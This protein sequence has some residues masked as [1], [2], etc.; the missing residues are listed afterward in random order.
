V[1]VRP[2][3]TLAGIAARYGTSVA[4]LVELNQIRN[5]DL[6]LPGQVVELA[7]TSAAG[8]SG[9]SASG[10]LVFHVVRPGENLT[11]L[12]ASYGTS[13]AAV[14]RANGLG[15]PNW[16][17]I[18]QRL[19][20]PVAASASTS[21][22]STSA[23]PTSP[24][25]VRAGE[26]LTGIARR[27]GTT[28]EALVRLNHLPWSDFIRIGQRIL[29]PAVR[30]GSDPQTG[31]ST[32][33]FPAAIRALMAHRAVIRDLIADEARRAG[34]PVPLALA[35]A[36]QE[37]GW[38]QRVVSSAGAV[39]VMQLLPST[40][41]WVADSMLR[42]PIDIHSSRS[43]IRGGV[44]LLKHYLLRYRGDL[45]RVLA[46]YYQGQGAVD[47]HGIFPISRPYI[48]SILLLEELLQP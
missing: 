47:H 29:V 10:S 22:S 21:R 44:A 28:V 20:I 7:P 5:P 26:T 14:A 25:V 32:A 13:V 24:Y 37:S 8:P 46:A 38:R 19:R 17:E 30:A 16:I 1:V 6:I 43:N 39:G 4:R 18:G 2:G 31:W 12:A 36:W 23:N 11:G 41:Q 40:A 33:R 45:R 3:D 34:V 15:N 35:V 27:H 42:A 9:S 48:A